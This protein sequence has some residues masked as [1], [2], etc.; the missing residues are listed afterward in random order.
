MESGFSVKYENEFEVTAPAGWSQKAAPGNHLVLCRGA[1]EIIVIRRDDIRL[2]EQIS[3]EEYL[4]IV[5]ENAAKLRSFDKLEMSSVEPF[6]TTLYQGKIMT[7]AFS[8]DA[9]ATE[10]TIFAFKTENYY[11]LLMLQVPADC[12]KEVLADYFDIVNSFRVVNENTEAPAQNISGI[13][14]TPVYDLYQETCISVPDHW[15]SILDMY[16]KGMNYSIFVSSQDRN[17][18]VG[19]TE[20]LKPEGYRL[21]QAVSAVRESYP[22]PV[23]SSDYMIL[24]IN[25]MKALQYEEENVTQLMLLRFL[26]TVVESEDAFYF[27]SCW[28]PP[29][30]FDDYAEL[31][32]HVTSS[33][34]IC[35]K[36]FSFNP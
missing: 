5:R 10:T 26:N 4:I 31:F 7:Y 11:Y 24:D 29:A 2:F 20:L 6:S 12:H 33:F 22:E 23:K 9:K 16:N 32:R 30:F 18:A 25:G 15:V 34:T 21:A 3:L 36:I 14:F 13:K 35:K 27:I 19:V 28:T 1:E 17:Q 8:F